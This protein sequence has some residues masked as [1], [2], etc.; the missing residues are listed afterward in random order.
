MA[1]A[2]QSFFLDGTL[3]RA[4]DE[5]KDVPAGLERLFELPKPKARK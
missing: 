4:G 1:V 5:V 3:I 2:N